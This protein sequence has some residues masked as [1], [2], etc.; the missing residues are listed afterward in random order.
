MI[1]SN[2]CQ[3]AI[4]SCIYLA[5]KRDKAGVGEIAE[6]INSPVPFTSKILQKL[7]KNDMISSAKGRSGG[8][9][10]SEQQYETLTVGKV[11][12]VTDNEDLLLGCV[13]GLSD[14]NEKNPCP[15]H[16]IAVGIK[17]RV[18]LILELRISEMKDIGNIQFLKL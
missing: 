5:M 7:A 18:R 2:S 15:V 12:K 6:F 9:Y 16:H 14:C 1:F 10:L 17:E 4:K 3:Y 11:C 13:L 8:F